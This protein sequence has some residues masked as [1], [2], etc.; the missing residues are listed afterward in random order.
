MSTEIVKLEGTIRLLWHTNY[1]NGP[2]KGLC[3]YNGKKY[4]FFTIGDNYK[5]SQLA[6]FTPTEEKLGY[7][8]KL[9]AENSVKIGYLN[10]YGDVYKK[11]F[12]EGFPTIT[13]MIIP[14]YDFSSGL[15]YLGHVDYSQ[16]SNPFQWMD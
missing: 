4:V 15:E 8:E 1:F 11:R 12:T 3:L 14:S 7:L 13:N 10:D 6:L 9:H 2:D 16:I 5:T